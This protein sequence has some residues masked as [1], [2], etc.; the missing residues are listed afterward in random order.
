MK[1]RTKG[2][3]LLGT[4]G[5][6]LLVNNVSRQRSNQSREWGNQSWT[7][8]FMPPHPLTYFEMQNYYQNEFKFKS[9]YLQNSLPNTMKNGA[10]VINLDEHKSIGTHWIALYANG[11]SV[12][13]F[14]RFNVEH[15]PKEIKSFIDNSNIIKNIFKIQGYNSAMCDNSALDL[16]ILC[17]KAKI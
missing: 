12:R 15:I 11:N 14:D 5:A 4:I 8:F 9:L 13:Y 10:Y 7:G 16:L 1:Q 17:V 2:R 6:N 3:I